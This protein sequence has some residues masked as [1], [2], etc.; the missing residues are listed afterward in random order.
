M[1][2]IT[3]TIITALFALSAAITV[4]HAKESNGTDIVVA[5]NIIEAVNNIDIISLNVLLAEGAAADTVDE[6]GNSPLILAARIGNPRMIRIILA[7]SP[8]I[9]HRNNHGDTAL[10]VAAEYGILPIVRQLTNAGADVQQRNSHGFIPE[11][12][13]QRNGHGA[14]ARYLNNSS[15]SASVSR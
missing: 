7:H 15:D 4:V 12:I 13:A 3:V 8:E 5:E 10:M 1:K 14:V 9:G 6:A 11:Q 2:T